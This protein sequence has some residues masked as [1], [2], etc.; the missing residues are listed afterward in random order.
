[1]KLDIEKLSL[2]SRNVLRASALLGERSSIPVLLQAGFE[3]VVLDP[4]FGSGLLLED[5]GS[6][7]RFSDPKLVTEEKD[8]T[9]WSTKRQSQ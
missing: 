8:R 7:A 2:E 9:P 4:L 1:M 6:L 3:A 5:K